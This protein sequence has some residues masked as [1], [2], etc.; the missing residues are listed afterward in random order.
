M[1]VSCNRNSLSIYWRECECE[2]EC[3]GVGVGVGV[4]VTRE[5]WRLGEFTK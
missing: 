4:C 3:D 1:Y 2:C 5:E